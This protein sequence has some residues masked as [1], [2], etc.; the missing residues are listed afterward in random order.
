MPL[1][2]KE[3]TP[4]GPPTQEELSN[5]LSNVNYHKSQVKEWADRA[6]AAQSA[7]DSHNRE[8]AKAQIE[9]DKAQAKFDN[10]FTKM[11]GG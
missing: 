5:A 7:L 4:Q 8:Q 3:E 10:I 1:T 2:A 9:L 6:K 11:K